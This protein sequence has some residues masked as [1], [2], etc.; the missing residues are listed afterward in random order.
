MAGIIADIESVINVVLSQAGLMQGF[1]S[2]MEGALSYA[3]GML[4][5]SQYLAAIPLIGIEFKGIVDVLMGA[6]EL[7]IGTIEVLASSFIPD[8]F[9]GIFTFFVFAITWM[10]CLFKNLGNMQTC[11]M[12]Y[13]LEVVGQILYLPIRIILWIGHEIG[14]DLYEKETMFWKMIEYIDSIVLN[15][16]GFHICHYPRNIRD[17]CYNCRRLKVSALTS[18]SA[19]LV[20]DITTLIPK[21]LMPGFML[22]AKGGEEIM[23]PF[24]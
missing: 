1:M 3:T 12:Y 6:G 18:H 22:M 8:L 14:I 13:L 17:L 2:T 20:Y 15:Y 21:K 19:P 16:L 7:F 10:M 23:N 9:D 4:M 24:G 5:E 11:L